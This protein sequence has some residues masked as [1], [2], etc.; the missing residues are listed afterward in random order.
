MRIMQLPPQLVAA[1]MQGREAAT[2][3]RRAELSTAC[4][5]SSTASGR[6]AMSGGSVDLTARGDL[7]QEQVLQ[8]AMHLQALLR[9]GRQAAGV[10]QRP[11]LGLLALLAARPH[12]SRCR[13]ASDAR[14]ASGARRGEALAR[15]RPPQ[16]P[17]AAGVC[18][19]LAR[20]GTFRPRSA[21]IRDAAALSASAGTADGRH[22][23][24]PT[25]RRRRARL[26]IAP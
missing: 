21:N 15:G 13:G 11:L 23:R 5:S 18:G 16:R 17:P 25:Q 22:P 12:W 7:H 3:Q 4:H 8:L 20:G 19:A 26:R 9:L 6:A 2:R 14:G 24:R 1:Q 10:L